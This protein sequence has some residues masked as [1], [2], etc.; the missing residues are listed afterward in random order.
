MGRR[1]P[2]GEEVKLLE[3]TYRDE[4]AGWGFERF[5][6]DRDLTLLV[7]A[8]GVGK[9]RVLQAIMNLKHLIDPKRSGEL[10]DSLKWNVRF[11]DDEGVECQ[12]SGHRTLVRSERASLPAELD[13]VIFPHFFEESLSRDGI[14]VFA[15]HAEQFELYGKK[16][17][18]KLSFEESGIHLL[19]EE[20]CRRARVA[21]SRFLQ[22]DATEEMSETP[23]RDFE[24][25]LRAAVK[26][27]PT[28]E[29]IREARLPTRVKLAVVQRN[30]PE[31]FQQIVDDFRDIFPSVESI[32]LDQWAS[33]DRPGTRLELRFREKGIE[34]FIE[35]QAMSQGM[36]RTLMHL[37]RLALW[38]DGTV[39][40]IDEFENGL[41]VNCI[42]SVARGLL[43]NSSRLQFI[44]T[45]HHPYIINQIP[46]DRWKIL[47]REGGRIE[48]FTAEQ[49]HLG[50]SKHTAF[51]QLTN[52]KVFRTGT[53]PDE[54]LFPGGRG[55]N[56]S[57]TLPGV[58]EGTPA[59]PPTG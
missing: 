14:S 36:R 22:V 47:A 17:G 4:G 51:T 30:E 40:L 45:S 15:R 1:H 33:D 42:D 43:S 26:A 35:Q 23:A 37:A 48:A 2:A 50:R 29:T 13:P 46:M 41:G 6:F 7:G 34:G 38:P 12:W 32:S 44:A 27:L 20:A 49:L 53:M 31:R 16:L 25:P 57:A 28:L 59:P 54:S 19:D 58:A 8:S 5:T 52:S 56:G 21:L 24:F 10:P 55:L 39:L 3:L 11:E 18:A 9:T